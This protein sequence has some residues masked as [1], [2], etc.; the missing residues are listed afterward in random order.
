M[1]T[2][3]IYARIAVDHRK[4]LSDGKLSIAICV[5]FE[6]NRKYYRTG[7]AISS[8]AD[9]EKLMLSKRLTIEQN[10]VK[11]ALEVK[12]RAANNIIA[13]LEK[14]GKYDL[15][16]FDQLFEPPK[17]RKKGGNDYKY[18][19]QTYQT[20]IEHLKANNQLKTAQTYDLACKSLTGYKQ[21]MKFQDVTPDFL[22]SW[23]KSLI[24]KGRSKTT[25][26]MYVRTLRTLFNDGIGLGHLDRQAYPF[27][28][29]KYKIPSSRNIK[30]ALSLPDI[31]KIYNYDCPTDLQAEAKDY[32]LFLYLNNGMNVKDMALLK[33]KDYQN[34]EIQ[35]VRAKTAT[36]TK[37]IEPIPIPVSDET[38]EIIRRR[39]K[40]TLS[41]ND[42]IFPILDKKMTEAEKMR[43]I[44]QV[45][46]NINKNMAKITA[47]LQLPKVTTY[48]ARHSYATVLLH[49]GQ[50][51]AFIGKQLGHTDTKTTENYLKSFNLEAVKK[52]NEAL[53][54]FK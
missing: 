31:G 38:K 20:K 29:R 50:S 28:K 48:T 27:G 13:D 52:A 1:S 36:T 4:K 7:Y 5:T 40:R 9:L 51:V 47:V 15:N 30:K 45:T 23:E 22:R 18:I 24:D 35:F 37:D 17:K 34:D 6:T 11:E 25:V 39:G 26:S 42:Y 53:T 12:L 10:D 19:S 46:Q 2:K 33:W 54:S 44:Q 3:K 49:S 8:H 21:K 41:P 32:W 14:I 16:D 43:A